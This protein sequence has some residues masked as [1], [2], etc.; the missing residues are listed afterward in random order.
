M[1][2]GLILFS[3]CIVILFRIYKKFQAGEHELKAMGVPQEKPLPFIGN[4]W[5]FITQKEGI[6][7]FFDRCYKLFPNEK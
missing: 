1:G 7:Q 2:F 6:M 3:L 5:P 4:I